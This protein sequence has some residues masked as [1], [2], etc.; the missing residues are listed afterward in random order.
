MGDSYALEIV[1]RMSRRD[2]EAL[3]LELCELGRRYHLKVSRF[4]VK[5]VTSASTEPDSSASSLNRQALEGQLAPEEP[6]RPLQLGE[7]RAPVPPRRSAPPG[8]PNSLDLAP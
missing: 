3:A 4:T 5:P 2:A 7:E 6:A 8:R 1:S